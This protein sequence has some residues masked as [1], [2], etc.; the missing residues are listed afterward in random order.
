MKGKVLVTGANGFI[1]SHLIEELLAGGYQVRGLV[2]KTSNLEWL[3]GRNLD[4]CLGEVTDKQSLY[5]AVKGIDFI[6]HTAGATKGKDQDYFIVNEEGTK[7]LL[8]ACLEQ[9]PKIKRIVYFSSLAAVGPA[10]DLQPKNEMSECRPVSLYGAAKR[11]AEQLVI[12]YSRKLPTVILRVPTVYGPRDREGLTYFKLLKKG[13]RPILGDY[14]SIVFIKDV[15]RAAILCLEKDVKSGEIF[16][17]SDG[18]CY[19]FDD[20]A[21]IAEQLMGVRT[22]RFRVPKPILSIYTFLLTK[23]S[24]GQSIINQDKIKE[25]TQRCWI[26]NINKIKNELGFNPQFGLA[27]GLKLT[28]GWYKERRWL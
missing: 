24:K 1:G 3:A 4:L 13:L 14:F 17:V 5:P 21:K 6:L 28:I 20:I 11:K 26:C 27:E 7:N 9:N 19:T 2:R 18:N 23:F 22:L 15:V 16:F 10:N 8:T 12:E 25:L